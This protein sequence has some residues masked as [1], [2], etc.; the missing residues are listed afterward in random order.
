MTR[1]YAVA[2]ATIIL[3]RSRRATSRTSSKSMRSSDSVTPYATKRN[4]FPLAF[5]GDPCVRWP[6]WSRR[7][8]STVS[9]GC[10]N[11]R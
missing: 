1:G 11:A 4:S 10:N 5:T 2:P 7:I 9:P 6:P 8:P 3:G